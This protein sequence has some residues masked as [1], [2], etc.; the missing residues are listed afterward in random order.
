LKAAFFRDFLEDHSTWSWVMEISPFPF[1]L[2]TFIAQMKTGRF[3]T[4]VLQK[5]KDELLSI[6]HG[7]GCDGLDHHNHRF[8]SE[9]RRS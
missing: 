9:R 7:N 3:A 4:S 2:A 5:D 6:Y 8:L 1:S